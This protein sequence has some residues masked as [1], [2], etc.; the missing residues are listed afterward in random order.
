MGFALMTRHVTGTE[1]VIQYTGRDPLPVKYEFRSAGWGGRP[2]VERWVNK[3]RRHTDLVDQGTNPRE[4][5]KP[6]NQ[7]IIHWNII[8]I[9]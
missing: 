7:C 6:K 3:G 5:P 9:P 2:G 1:G 4:S 8:I